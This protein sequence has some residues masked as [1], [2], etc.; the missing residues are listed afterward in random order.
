M[1]ASGIKILM[2][3]VSFYHHINMEHILYLLNKYHYNFSCKVLFPI[4]KK[5]SR[6]YHKGYLHIVASNTLLLQVVTK[7]ARP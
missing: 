4:C 2:L 6:Y 3:M 5:N 1:I 7:V